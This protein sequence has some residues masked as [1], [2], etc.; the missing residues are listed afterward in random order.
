MTGVLMLII[1]LF[2]S[3]L[4]QAAVFGSFTGVA[5]FFP[6]HALFG[7]LIMHRYSASLGAAWITIGAL[8]I[9]QIGFSPIPLF[10]YVCC[11]LVGVPLT[12]YVFASR[13]MYAMIG[14]ACTFFLICIVPVVLF[15]RPL[16]SWHA[17]MLL[18]CSY[19]ILSFLLA[20]LAHAFERRFMT[21]TSS[22]F[23]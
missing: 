7:S 2:F 11:A 20:R 13:S 4:V 3:S 22:L 6:A 23:S 18:F 5:L 12:Q 14:L 16:I 9:P 21:H 15:V 10:S 1:S 8:L 19:V 17:N